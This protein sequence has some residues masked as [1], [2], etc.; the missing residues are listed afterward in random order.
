MATCGDTAACRVGKTAILGPALGLLVACAAPMPGDALPDRAADAPSSVPLAATDSAVAAAS[1]SSAPPELRRFM[2]RPFPW[3]PVDRIVAMARDDSRLLRPR[4]ALGPAAAPVIG[5]VQAVI[6]ARVAVRFESDAV[7]RSLEPRGGYADVAG[8]H[9][10]VEFF[11][12]DG[13]MCIGHHTP[14]QGGRAVQV[15]D[16]VAVQTRRR[17]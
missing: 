12:C 3:D 7:A 15:G 6:G 14:R 13:S 16:V 5:K 11:L 9:G 2:L 17:R 4:G 10:E 8:Y 1:D